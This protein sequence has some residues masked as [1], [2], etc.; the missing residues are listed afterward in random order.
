MQHIPTFWPLYLGAIAAKQTK[1]ATLARPWSNL[2]ADVTGHSPVIQTPEAV[3]PIRIPS[4]A[5]SAEARK[6]AVYR[7]LRLLLSRDDSG[8]EPANAAIIGAY[9]DSMVRR[10]EYIEAFLFHQVCDSPPNTT[11]HPV[12]EGGEALFDSGLLPSPIGTF[13]LDVEQIIE[14]LL[15]AK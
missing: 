14:K 15:N 10:I 1:S 13:A 6:P 2:A 11:P 9:F 4:S 8:D 3:I 7:Q 5:P 12:K